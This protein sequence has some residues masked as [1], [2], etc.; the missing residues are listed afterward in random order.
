MPAEY[1]NCVRSE[2]KNGKSR[3]DAQRICAISYYKR[4]GR[5]PQEDES[6]LAQMFEEITKVRENVKGQSGKIISR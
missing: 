3:K 1:M 2:M 6:A 4:H 5:T